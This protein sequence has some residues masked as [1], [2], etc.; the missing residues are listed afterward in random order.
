MSNSKHWKE[1]WQS[2]ILYLTNAVFQNTFFQIQRHTFEYCVSKM[3][4]KLRIAQK[5]KAE[6]VHRH[7][8]CLTRNTEG[9]P[10]N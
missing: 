7:Y 3:K 8:T 4:E 1:N 6:G 2:I 10:A 9:I 5:T